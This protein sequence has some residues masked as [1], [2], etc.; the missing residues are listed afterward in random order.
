[1][2]LLFTDFIINVTSYDLSNKFIYYFLF[3]YIRYIIDNIIDCF[4]IY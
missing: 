2:Y 1:M 3:C 4:Y